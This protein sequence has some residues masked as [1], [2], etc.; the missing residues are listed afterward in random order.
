MECGEEKKYHAKG[1]CSKCYHAHYEKY[2]RKPRVRKLWRPDKDRN[3]ARIARTDPVKYKKLRV[4]KVAL[5]HEQKVA[6][7]ILK[8]M[9]YIPKDRWDSILNAPLEARRKY[10]PQ[11]CSHMPKCARGMCRSCYQKWLRF[12]NKRYR[13]KCLE[14]QRIYMSEQREKGRFARKYKGLH[15]RRA[16]YAYMCRSLIRGL[17]PEAY[18]MLRNR[19]KARMRK[20]SDADEQDGAAKAAG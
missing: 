14:K 9:K 15:Q 1:L 5:S 17:S 18:T 3:L 4:I 13:L 20:G 19:V 10:V 7:K 8:L 12:H 11:G 6:R 2:K 16:D